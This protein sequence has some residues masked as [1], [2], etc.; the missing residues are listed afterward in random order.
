MPNQVI[1]HFVLRG[2]VQ[3]WIYELS[4]VWMN[5]RESLWANS[6]DKIWMTN[7]QC[8]VSWVSQFIV[9][10]SIKINTSLPVSQMSVNN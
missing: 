5:E 10:H 3:Q 4:I 6:V 2:I 8:E 9:T 7:G 1:N